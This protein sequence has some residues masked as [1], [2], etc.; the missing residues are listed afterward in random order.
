MSGPFGEVEPRDIETAPD[1]VWLV[2]WVEHLQKWCWG[3][4]RVH[5]RFGGAP[6]WQIK[7]GHSPKSFKSY[8]DFKPGAWLPVALP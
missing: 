8:V 4:R 1:D 7:F 3:R 5:P 6:R 2:V